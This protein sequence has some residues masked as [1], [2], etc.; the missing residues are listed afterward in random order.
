MISKL[1]LYR[2]PYVASTDPAKYLER[3]FIDEEQPLYQQV[4]EMASI[5]HLSASVV[6]P[7]G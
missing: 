6:D 3:H 1:R 4:R 7:T 5:P 2:R